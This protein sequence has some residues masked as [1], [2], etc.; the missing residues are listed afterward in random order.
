MVQNHGSNQKNSWLFAAS[1]R[2][3]DPGLICGL[4]H[5]LEDFFHVH[6]GIPQHRPRAF[7]IA[8]SPQHLFGHRSFVWNLRF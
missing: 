5:D 1:A 7:A 8:E 3:L 2:H 6:G 4:S